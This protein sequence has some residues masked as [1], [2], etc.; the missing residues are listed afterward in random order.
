MNLFIA[1]GTGTFGSR[2]I[3]A[4]R[5]TSNDIDKV[6]VYSRDH[7]KQRDLRNLYPKWKGLHFILGDI[8]SNRVYYSFPDDV[9]VI[10]NATDIADDRGLDEFGFELISLKI[11]G[12][13]KLMDL[14]KIKGCKYLLISNNAVNTPKS[15][16][17]CLSLV[18]EKT[19]IINGF[20]V[21][22]FPVLHSSDICDMIWE[23][24][25]GNDL[26]VPRKD[27]VRY[28]MPIEDAVD[29]MLY[30]IPRIIG[31]DTHFHTCQYVNFE[32]L[33]KAIVRRYGTFNTIKYCC[34]TFSEKVE[35]YD[36]SYGLGIEETIKLIETIK[37]GRYHHEFTINFKN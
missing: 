28:I 31:D 5:N 9:D 17:D 36:L 15:L 35:D 6:Y 32:M 26:I 4:I 27:A 7:N 11:K 29:Y 19:T 3:E 25:R 33:A 21:V 18:Q 30:I 34:D 16:Y 22:R 37:E 10:I 14:A 2:I 24:Q 13:L 23:A 1:G 8:R 20:S 12:H